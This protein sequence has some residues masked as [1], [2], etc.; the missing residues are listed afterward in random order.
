MLAEVVRNRLMTQ[1]AVVSGPSPPG[2]GVRTVAL[3]GLGGAALAWLAVLALTVALSAFTTRQALVRYRE[4]RTGWSWDLAYYNQWFWQVVH[5]RS[6]VTVQPLSAYALE[7]PQVWRMNY[8]APIRLV[9]LPAYALVPRPETLL[10]IQ[11][12]VIWLVIPAGFTLVRA[13]TRSTLIGLAGAGLV[14]FTP[15]LWPLVW[16]DFRELQLALP[17]VLWAVQGVRGRR[18]ALTVVGVGGMLACRQELAAVVVTLALLPA[19]APEDVGR[20]Y[21]WAHDLIVIGVAWVLFGFFA[22][23]QFVVGGASVK[24]YIRQFTGSKAPIEETL[25]TS[26]E[27]LTLGLGAW[28]V[29]LAASPRAALLVLPWLW[30]L[31]SGQWAIRELSTRNWHHVRYTAPFVAVGLA[32]GLVGFG[33][34]A[35]GLLRWRYGATWLSLLWVAAAGASSFAIADLAHRVAL[36]PRPIGP[37]EAR[38]VWRCIDQVGPEDVVLAHYDVAAPLSSRR[39][40]YSY[41]LMTNRPPRYPLLRPEFS[42]VF[43]RNDGLDLGGFEPQGFTVVHKGPALT[44]FRRIRPTPAR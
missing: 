39:S 20:S 37:E 8:L 23:L 5:G 36:Q 2:D 28:A 10:V 29:F 7:G 41:V 12:M 11:N 44:I 16:N 30:S 9:L 18:L 17:F 40:L 32:A 35:S 15:L 4:F 21:R 26:A 25:C 27:F 42:W 19:R 6:A 34:V 38:E 31:S 43:Y 13:E 1:R 3:R 33:R 24:D 14:P 22:Y